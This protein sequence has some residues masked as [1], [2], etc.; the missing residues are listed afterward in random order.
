MGDIERLTV[1][2]PE[3]AKM[4]GVTT[5]TAYNLIHRADFPVVRVGRRAI[6]PVD[7]LKRWVEA[8]AGKK[9]D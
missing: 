5:C 3:M 2:V 1:T 6:I 4:L 9:N 7:A 8:Q